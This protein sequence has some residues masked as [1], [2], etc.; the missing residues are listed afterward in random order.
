MKAIKDCD[1]ALGKF[2]AFAWFRIKGAI[3]DSQKGKAFREENAISIQ[4][5]HAPG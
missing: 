3:I 1:P 2:E 5:P 4:S